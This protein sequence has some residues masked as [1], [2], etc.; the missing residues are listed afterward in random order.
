MSFI[1]IMKKKFY[2][3]VNCV[4]YSSFKYK[5]YKFSLHIASF[6]ISII[7][8]IKFISNKIFMTKYKSFIF[9]CL[10]EFNF[11]H[12]MVLQISRFSYFFT[13]FVFFLAKK[14]SCKQCK[15]RKITLRLTDCFRSDMSF[16]LARKIN[17][18]ESTTC[19]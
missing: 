5:L 4:I 19:N 6:Y 3:L 16:S 18:S 12:T 1:R 14:N 2:A 8:I 15:T 17:C 9:F 10:K 11:S 13:L 7:L